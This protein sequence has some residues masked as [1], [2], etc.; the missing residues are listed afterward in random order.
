LLFALSVAITPP[1]LFVTL[2]WTI[3]AIVASCK[4]AKWFGI[5]FGL[6]AA[7]LLVGAPLMAVYAMKPEVD[8]DGTTLFGVIIMSVAAAAYGLLTFILCGILVATRAYRARPH[9][10][11]SE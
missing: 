5:F 4:G 8:S 7:V 3:L 10:N 6:N 11:G 2:P 1:I 9:A